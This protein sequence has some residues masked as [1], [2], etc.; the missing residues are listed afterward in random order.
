MI[1]NKIIDK[2]ENISVPIKA[3]FWYT[4]CNFINKGISLLATPIFTRIMTEEQYGTF[5]IF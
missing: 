2:Y 1:H 5:S 4:I 3:A